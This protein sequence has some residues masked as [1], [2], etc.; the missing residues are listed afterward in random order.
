[1]DNLTHSLIGAALGQAG[2]KRKTGLAM[3]TL[4]IAANIPDIDAGCTVLGM[5]SLAM[6]RGVTHGPI[7]ML[8]LP[9]LLTGAMI[10]YDRRQARRGTRPADRPPLRPGWLLALAYIG[11]LSHPLFDWMNSYGIRLLEPFSHRWFYGD[12]LFIVDPWLLVMLT[13]GIWFSVRRERASRGDWAGPA[14]LAVAGASAYVLANLGISA[15]AADRAA[16]YAPYPEVVVANPVPAAFWRREVLWR[17]AGRYGSYDVSLFGDKRQAQPATATGMD[18]PRLP[19][20]AQANA[21]ARAFLFWSR[22]PVARREGEAI[23]LGDQRF[24]NS[25]TASRF[26]LRLDP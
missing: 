24:M 16:M 12:A 10:A 4:I 22:M 14:R 21:A 11:C 17:G 6:R 15:L 20:R 9:L 23:V 18:D 26:N 1:M 3:P 13:A 8:L 2:L 19:A 25:P 5:V 7:A